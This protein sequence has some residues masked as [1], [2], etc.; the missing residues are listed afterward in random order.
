MPAI[1]S[2]TLSFAL[3]ALLLPAVSAAQDSG[4]PGGPSYGTH[5]RRAPARAITI[6]ATHEAALTAGDPT[7]ADDSHFH[8]W[9]FSAR[10][11]QDV[12]V[13]LESRDFDAVAMLVE[14]RGE[15]LEPLQME[16]ADSAGSARFAVRI[17]ADGDYLIVANTLQPK[18]TGSY[19]ISLSTL[20]AACA[21]GGPCAVEGANPGDLT[22]ISRID[23]NA[24]RPITLGDSTQAELTRADSRLRDSSFFDAWRFEG[25]EG[26]RIV[27]DHGSRDFDTYL[28]LARQTEN[29]PES[30]RE[31]DDAPYTRDSQLAVELPATGTYV[32]VA[33]SLRPDTV[34]RY[35]LRLRSLASACAA[36]GPCATTAGSGQRVPLFASVPSARRAPLAL[37]DTVSARLGRGDAMLGDGTFF[38]AYRFTGAAGD[39]VAILLSSAAPN[40]GRMDPFLYLLRVDA[41]TVVVVKSDDDGGA[42]NNSMIT[43]RLPDAGEYIVLAN[44]L[45]VADTGSYALSFMRLSD[46]CA[47]L[48][49]CEVGAEIPQAS[50]EATILAARATRIA[51]G[52]TVT[53]KLESESLKLPDGKPFQAWRYTAGAGERVVITNRSGDFDAYLQLYHV[54]DGTLRE[55][56]RNDDGGG[57]LDAQLSVELAEAGDYLIVAGS[58]STSAT[59]DYRL[60]LEDM[61]AACAAGGPCAVGETSAGRDRLLP[62]LTA[63]FAP[64]PPGD[65]VSAELPLSAP[66]M[67]GRGRFQSYRFDG[68]A[69]ERI[70]VT[71]DAEQFDPYLDLALVRGSSL[72]VI[73]SDDDGGEG[74]NARLVATL[75]ETGT[76]LLVA[77]A[78]S[79]DSA[80]GAGP[81]T[82]TRGPCDDACAADDGT[83]AVRSPRLPGLVSRA[84][85][86]AMPRSGVVADSL[87]AADARRNGATFHAF[88]FQSAAGQTLRASLQ[89]V[90]F[91]PFL[92][93]LRVEG[94]SLRQIQTDDDSGEGTNSLV[95][96]EI[97]RAG[98]YVIVAT[99]YSGSSRGSYVLHVAQGSESE[100]AAFASTIAAAGARAQLGAALSAPHRALPRG[101]SVAGEFAEQ[102]PRLTGKGRFQSYRFSGR[103]DESVVV[104]MESGDTDP[105]LY[106]ASVAG[107]SVRIVGTDDDG[108]EGVNARLVATL[109]VTGEYLVVATAYASSD[110]A[111]VAR[112][113]VTLDS[114]DDACAAEGAEAPASTS[115]AAASR[116]I[117]AAPRRSIQP[118]VPVRAALVVGDST[119][120]DGSYFHAYTLE[121]TAGSVVRASIESSAFDTFLFLY[122]VEGD[123]LVRVAYDDDSGEDTNSLIEWT[124]DTTGSYILVANALSRDSHGEY[125]LAVSLPARERAH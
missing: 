30:V 11:G 3:S 104:T 86:R 71:L 113:S 63:A 92:V 6:G 18:R 77:S 93:V 17:P 74:V 89:S 125:T 8:V 41:D 29:G 14:A 66:Q 34:G 52:D 16:M 2:L 60:S 5:A 22:A 10:A 38:D 82:L 84:E 114:C 100:G 31:N 81:Y 115:D 19:R 37:G 45:T 91:D 97:D 9:R 122:R 54:G 23:V 55:V 13:S 68:R 69:G 106:L 67:P 36:G 51:L 26:E 101:T 72:S 121:A 111:R 83:P 96:W 33:T 57:S 15:S 103:A 124:V 80:R 95:E 123:S 87:T 119:L 99:S 88:A 53:G 105:F 50:A 79:A 65:T 76:Y 7:F 94:D 102:T 90:E 4:T 85:R 59:G 47:S 112:Y 21:A 120:A 61:R 12:A 28:I 39:E 49:V 43:A 58:F 24:A 117:L 78:L 32:I 25:R 109:P 56:E 42:G 48:R 110:T 118:G 27:I 116:R 64:F 108:G 20:S 75:P 35:T 70:V 107:E 98:T 1:G 44:G 40:S 73:G 62:A 46:A